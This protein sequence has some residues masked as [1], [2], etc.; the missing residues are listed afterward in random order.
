MLEAV[1][2][3]KAQ[4]IDMQ[5]AMIKPKGRKGWL[6]KIKNSQH[7]WVPW[8][9]N[10]VRW[11]FYNAEEK[12]WGRDS[13]EKEQSR[14]RVPTGYNCTTMLPMWQLWIPRQQKAEWQE[15]RKSGKWKWVEFQMHVRSYNCM[16]EA[17]KPY[18][19]PEHTWIL[20]YTHFYINKALV[21]YFSYLYRQYSD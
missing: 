16:L 17:G 11:W 4:K 1:D 12:E 2:K 20:D 18:W 21:C 8:R 9:T 5:H 6:R 19:W 14:A 13:A 3:S 15:N 7:R 10:L